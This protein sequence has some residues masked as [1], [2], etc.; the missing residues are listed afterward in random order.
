VL[1]NDAFNGTFPDPCTF[2]LSGSPSI[3]SVNSQLQLHSAFDGKGQTQLT[4]NGS[5]IASFKRDTLTL[6]V[7]FE[8]HE[9]SG[10]TYNS[11]TG[12]ALQYNT[13][14]ADSSNN[15][16]SWDTNQDGDPTNDNT[17]TP[18]VITAS[19]LFIPNGFSP[20][21]DGRYDRFVIRG[22]NGRSAK[23]TVYNRWGN[24]VYDKEPY[25]NS[26]NGRDNMGNSAGNGLLP[27]AT[28][29]FILRFNDKDREIK[30]GFVELRY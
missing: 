10:T 13:I 8:P 15:G 14:L 11:V 28:Y 19:N 6:S 12:T 3:T 23:L 21:D 27:A 16:F 7:L 4:S 18:L 30:T 1:L 22:L 24:V 5:S 20:N 2:T 26:W 17:P 25:D 9:F 29:Y